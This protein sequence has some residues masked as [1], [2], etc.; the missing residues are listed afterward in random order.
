MVAVRASY[1]GSRIL[2]TAIR[3][4]QSKK[5]RVG[6]FDTARYQDGTPVAYIAAIQ[7]FGHGA[8]PPRPFMRPTI[9][10]QRQAWRDT[11]RKGAKQVLAERLTFEQMLTAFGLSAAGQVAESIKA[12]T[13]PPLSPI[14]LLLR[15]KAKTGEKITG[16]T[17]GMAAAASGFVPTENSGAVLGVS[18]KPLIDTA[19]MLKSVT[20]QVSDE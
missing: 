13:A 19:L 14:T 18:D 9:A 12:V 4:I 20:A 15:Q 6:W 7:E 10:Q 17:V 11:L 16:R 8:I 3:D 1:V 5:L 2:A